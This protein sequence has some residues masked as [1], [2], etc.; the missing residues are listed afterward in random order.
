M[1]HYSLAEN[2]FK[3]GDVDRAY[4]YIRIA[5]EDALFYN[6]RFKKQLLP[7]YI[8]L[9]KIH[10]CKIQWQQK[11]LGYTLTLLAFLLLYLLFQLYYLFRQ[12]KATSRAKRNLDC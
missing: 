3:S 9:L 4:N 1:K 12:I 6:A 7:E 10:T 11:N 5:L 2:L 8:L